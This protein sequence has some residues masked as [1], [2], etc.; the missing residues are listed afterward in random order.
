MR[1]AVRLTPKAASE[2]IDG[3]DVDAQGRPV[4]KVRVRAA[5]IDGKANA[6]L[7]ALMAKALAIP[8]SRVRLVGGETARQK[9]L[10]IDGI[11]PAQLERW[12][13]SE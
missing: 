1:L 12:A 7:V 3:W 9:I 6:A 5:P 13:Q 11:E 8:R 2:G 10:D 4:L